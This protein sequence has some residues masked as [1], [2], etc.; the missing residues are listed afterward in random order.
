MLCM[1]GVTAQVFAVRLFII[2]ENTMVLDG[3]PSDASM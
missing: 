2:S 1:N 3:S